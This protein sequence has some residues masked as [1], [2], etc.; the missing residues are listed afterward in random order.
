MYELVKKKST[1]F[2]IV[3]GIIIFAFISLVLRMAFNSDSTIDKDLVNAENEI[4]AHA[5]MIIDSTTRLDRVSALPGKIFQ[6]NLTITSMEASEVDTNLLKKTGK[7]S[8][9][10][11]LKDN[12]QSAFF[13]DN[14]VEVQAVY[15]DSTGKRVTSFSVLPNEY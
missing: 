9:L 3:F 4:N 8:I 13:R 14:K 12:P 6:Y 1:G 7:E 11:K 5:P 15:V 2:N 10:V